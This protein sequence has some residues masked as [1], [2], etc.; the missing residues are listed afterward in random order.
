MGEEKVRT[1]S[2]LVRWLKGL[3][4]PAWAKVD[5]A[6]IMRLHRHD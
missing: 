4:L 2:D 3:A 5:V 6:V 1:S